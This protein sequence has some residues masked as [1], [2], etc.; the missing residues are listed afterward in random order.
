[1]LRSRIK[2]DPEDGGWPCPLAERERCMLSMALARV[3]NDESFGSSSKGV[4]FLAGEAMGMGVDATDDIDLGR[5]A[6][7][8]PLPF[9]GP[10]ATDEVN[11][12]LRAFTAAEGAFVVVDDRDLPPRVTG[13]CRSSTG[14]AAEGA[15]NGVVPYR[16]GEVGLDG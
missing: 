15:D 9:V 14:G 8:P 2:L 10:F 3:P 6:R 12:P 7:P 5:L 11:K 1:M 16:V 13:W 4:G